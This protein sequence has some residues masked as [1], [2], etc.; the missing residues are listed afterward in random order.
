MSGRGI[1]TGY[2]QQLHTSSEQNNAVQILEL[3][4]GSLALHKSQS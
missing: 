4:L 2:A 1:E 3:A